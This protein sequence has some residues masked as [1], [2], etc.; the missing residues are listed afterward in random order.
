MDWNINRR[1]K[2]KL[3]RG[4]ANNLSPLAVDSENSE[5][6]TEVTNTALDTQHCSTCSHKEPDA[7]ALA[8][9]T[10]PDVAEAPATLAHPFPRTTEVMPQPRH[11]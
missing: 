6:S 2:G 8:N 1:Q 9:L 5:A 10:I 4:R 11:P 7:V 3:N